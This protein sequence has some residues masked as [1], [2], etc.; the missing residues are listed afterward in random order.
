MIRDLDK[1]IKQNELKLKKTSVNFNTVT[2]SR[3]P[4]IKK[5]PKQET[6]PY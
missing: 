5:K 6:T 1:Q 2:S 4:S 3:Q